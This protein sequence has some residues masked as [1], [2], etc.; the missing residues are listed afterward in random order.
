MLN[1]SD[2]TTSD[3]SERQPKYVPDPKAIEW[4]K[5]NSIPLTGLV[6]LGLVVCILFH[7]SPAASDRTRIK[8]LS[9]SFDHIVQGIA[10]IAGGMGHFHV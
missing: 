7:F 8:E 1:S 5:E 4:F 3:T 2:S 6:L 9:E 10:I